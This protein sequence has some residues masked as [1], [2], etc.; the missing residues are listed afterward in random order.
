[1]IFPYFCNL[2]S[3]SFRTADPFHLIVCIL[4]HDQI[5][6]LLKTNGILFQSH[7]SN[8]FHFLPL[9]QCIQYTVMQTPSESLFRSDVSSVRGSCPIE[10]FRRSSLS[11]GLDVWICFIDM[12]YSWTCFTFTTKIYL[13]IEIQT[14]SNKIYSI[15]S[16]I[17][18][19]VHNIINQL[20]STRQCKH[21]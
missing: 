20:I 7:K 19:P 15:Q 17:L 5:N 16:A 4:S 3:N 12:Q 10:L 9:E 1:M 14:H 2:I 8:I 11:F 6:Q 13:K 18:N 21:N